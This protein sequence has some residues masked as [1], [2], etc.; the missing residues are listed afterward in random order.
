M[1]VSADTCEAEVFQLMDI[2]GEGGRVLGV[3]GALE[4]YPMLWGTQG[5]SGIFAGYSEDILGYP[6]EDSCSYA[7]SASRQG[8]FSPESQ[9]GRRGRCTSLADGPLMA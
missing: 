5:I 1:Y 2:M 4:T 9:Q 8:S 3:L 6:V 7:R